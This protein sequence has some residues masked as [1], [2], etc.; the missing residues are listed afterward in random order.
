MPLEVRLS[1]HL[2]VEEGGEPRVVPPPTHGGFPGQT[3]N[4]SRKVSVCEDVG[5]AE[6]GRVH[7]GELGQVDGLSFVAVHTKVELEKNNGIW[8]RRLM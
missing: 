3:L 1:T 2:V 5:Q 4:A 6:A 7:L 8:F